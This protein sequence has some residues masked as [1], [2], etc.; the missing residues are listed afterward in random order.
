MRTFTITTSTTR[1]YKEGWGVACVPIYN[2]EEYD[3]SIA[4][5]EVLIVRIAESAVREIGGTPCVRPDGESMWFPVVNFQELEELWED[6]T[7]DLRDRWFATE[8]E[9]RGHADYTLKRWRNPE[10]WES[11]VRLT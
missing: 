7:H 2:G 6:D 4:D 9:A 1:T 8:E 3:D 10:P 5:I 11:F